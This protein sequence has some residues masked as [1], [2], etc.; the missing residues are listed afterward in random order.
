[1]S[2]SNWKRLVIVSL[3][4]WI[5]LGD[6]TVFAQ[7]LHRGPTD[8]T[9]QEDDQEARDL[10]VRRQTRL[11][12]LI[13]SSANGRTRCLDTW[14]NGYLVRV[15]APFGGRFEVSSVR[16]DHPEDAADL[17]VDRYKSVLTRENTAVQF[18]Q[19][20]VYQR[21]ER[22]FVNYKQLFADI[23]VFFADVIVKLDDQGGVLYVSS[24]VLRDTAI[25]ERPGFLE[26]VID[27]MRAMQLGLRLMS[28]SRSGYHFSASEPE[29]TIYAPAVLHKPGTVCLAWSMRIQSEPSPA[30]GAHILINA[31]DGSLVY[32]VSLVEYTG[33][34]TIYDSDNTVTNNPSEVSNPSGSNIPD[35]FLVNQYIEECFDFYEDIGFTGVSDMDVVVRL[36]ESGCPC[37]SGTAYHYSGTIHFGDGVVSD[38]TVGHEFTHAVIDNLQGGFEMT[39]ESGAICEGFADTFGQWIDQ[40][41]DTYRDNNA[42][43]T[44]PT[45]WTTDDSLADYDGDEREEWTL[46]EDDASVFREEVYPTG[47]NGT[48]I[49]GNSMSNPP[50]NNFPGVYLGDHWVLNADYTDLN[51]CELWSDVHTNARVLEK[52][53]YLLCEGSYALGTETLDGRVFYRATRLFLHCIDNLNDDAIFYDLPEVLDE[54]TREQPL[55]FSDSDR[56]KIVQACKE[57]GIYPVLESHWALDE[58]TG[59]T[60]ASDSVG[61]NTGIVNGATWIAGKIEGALSFD[62]T[63]HHVSLSPIKALK[64]FHVSISAWINS[65]TAASGYYPIVTQYAYSSGNYG[66]YFC[67]HDGKPAFYINEE[68]AVSGSVIDEHEWCHLVGIYDGGTLALYV[69]GELADNDNNANGQF[70]IDDTAY[71]GADSLDNYFDGLIDDVRVYNYALSADQIKGLS[72]YAQ[73][74][75]VFSVKDSSDESVA[76]IDDKGNLFLT[77]DLTQGTP[78]ATANDEFRIQ[79]SS[80]D[81]AIIDMTTGDMV[82]KGSVNEEV[83][84]LSLAS[85]F[86]V[87][88]STSNTVAYIDTLGNVFVKGKVYDNIPEL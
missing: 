20:C 74:P 1:M 86:I 55:S 77:G 3:W 45:P 16:T 87:K 5:C 78:S 32:K 88:D 47:N 22:T 50:A 13:Q 68:E 52:L 76:W 65:D 18:A 53:A 27:K 79:D 4:G 64:G 31:K 2:V 66:Y 51:N 35:V 80:S 84:D 54:A 67:L 23:P 25:L 6:F 69:N 26:P 71:I 62:G 8:T 75:T 61:D 7:P 46:Y 56:V 21:L 42:T 72:K 49:I 10:K 29:L 12:E 39:G 44:W 40:L 63:D 58:T 57:V 73:Y 9:V 33:D 28:E 36:C 34:W 81:V 11:N 41:N 85:H 30:A 82:V 15:S 60:T 14:S 19:D 43:L 83:S 38:D 59:S 37:P 17:F 48:T 70:G 24:N